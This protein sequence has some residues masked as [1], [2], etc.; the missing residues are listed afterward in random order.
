MNIFNFYWIIP[1]YITY[2]LISKYET[3]ILTSPFYIYY[4]LYFLKRNTNSQFKIL[5]D[6]SCSDFPERINRFELN[7]HLLSIKYNVRLNVKTYLDEITNIESINTLYSNSVWSERELWDLFG[8]Y[9]K[10]NNDLRRILTDYAFEGHPLRKDF[11]LTGYYELVYDNNQKLILNQFL[12]T[13]QE[14]RLYQYSNSW[15]N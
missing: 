5:T 7:Y 3:Y 6:I 4:I 1:K 12:E 15:N 10:N 9:F 14:F 2:F 11:P 13:T 8:V